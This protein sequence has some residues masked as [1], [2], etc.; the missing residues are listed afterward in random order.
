MFSRGPSAVSSTSTVASMPSAA[1]NRV[2]ELDDRL[3]RVCHGYVSRAA[4]SVLPPPTRF[5]CRS[6][7]GRMV[8]TFGGPIR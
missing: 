3:C 6:A 8:R 1:V 7:G 2:E 5:I 4:A